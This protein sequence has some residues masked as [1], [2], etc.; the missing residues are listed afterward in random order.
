[1]ND[2]EKM[3]RYYLKEYG[4]IIENTDIVSAPKAQPKLK[5]DEKPAYREYM[6]LSSQGIDALTGLSLISPKPK[7]SGRLH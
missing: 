3:Q 4:R 6:Q 7:R 1:M 5:Y 2:I